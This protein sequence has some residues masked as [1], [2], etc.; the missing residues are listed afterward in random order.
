MTNQLILSNSTDKWVTFA[1]FY[2][3]GYRPNNTPLIIEVPPHI[4]PKVNGP[5]IEVRILKNE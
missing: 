4:Q 5:V 2:E 3:E 1:V